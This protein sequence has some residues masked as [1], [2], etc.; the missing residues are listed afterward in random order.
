M[1]SPDPLRNLASKANAASTLLLAL[2]VL[3]VIAGIAS[4]FVGDRLSDFGMDWKFVVLGTVYV[5]CALW[6]WRRGSRGALIAG[7]A[8]FIGHALILAAQL[9]NAQVRMPVSGILIRMLLAI[10]LLEGIT[11]RTRMMNQAA[12]GSQPS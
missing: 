1:S 10:P 12:T 6:S 7:T 9:V 3:H 2:G 8:L 4:F 11:A 5:G